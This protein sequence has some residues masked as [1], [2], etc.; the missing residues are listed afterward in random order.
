MELK[1]ATKKE[2]YYTRDH[3]W[4]SFHES[5]AYIGICKF[6][7]TGFRQI[8][9]LKFTGEPG[10]RKQGE[11]IAT[12]GYND[13]LIALHMPVDGTLVTINEK[14]V[15]GNPNILLDCAESTAWMALIE[16]SVPK[17]RKDLLQARQYQTGYK[18]KHNK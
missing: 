11:V 14:L 1:H 13:Y 8:Q 6:K 18:Q 2:T 9:E 5:V 10:F 4:I 12:V 7:L 15:A 16:P 17:D 3:E